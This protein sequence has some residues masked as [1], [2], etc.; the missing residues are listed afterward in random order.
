MTREGYYERCCVQ[1]E[2]DLIFWVRQVFDGQ[3]VTGDYVFKNAPL[4]N[5]ARSSQATQRVIDWCK[6]QL[7][8]KAHV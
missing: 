8:E 3:T 6:V 4:R 7:K 1:R 5:I 2:Q